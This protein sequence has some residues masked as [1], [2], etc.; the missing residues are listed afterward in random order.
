MSKVSRFAFALVL[1]LTLGFGADVAG[2]W[3]MSADAPDGNTYKFTLAVKGSGSDMTGTVSSPEL[4]S[5]ALKEVAFSGNELTFK[6]P[7]GEVGLIAF[8]LTMTGDSLKGTLATPQGDTGTVEGTRE[9]AAAAATATSTGA[10]NVTGKWKL[11]VKSPS[12]TDILATLDVKQE[13]ATVSG[14]I[15]TDAGSTPISDG[16][17]DGND[18]QF[19]IPLGDGTYE[20]KGKVNGGEYKGEYKGPSGGGT[21]VGTRG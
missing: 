7:Y 2:N 11:V 13:G 8:K 1:S 15:A 10:V 3:K 6:L 12:G 20:V 21:F 14:D 16:K 5:V 4:G 18:F 17:V 19:K 9:A